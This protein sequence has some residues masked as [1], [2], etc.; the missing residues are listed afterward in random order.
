MVSLAK[1]MGKRGY[2]ILGDIGA[3]V[4]ENRI[5]ELVDYELFLPTQYNIDIKGICLYHKNDFDQLSEDQKSRLVEHHGK[6]FKI[7]SH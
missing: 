7:E 1:S 4:Y 6:I 2:S 3:F 5:N